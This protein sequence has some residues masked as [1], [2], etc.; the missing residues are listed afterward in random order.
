MATIIVQRVFGRAKDQEKI[1]VFTSWFTDNIEKLETA[2]DEKRP[3][4][5]QFL[6]DYQPQTSSYVVEVQTTMTDFAEE[7]LAK[8]KEIGFDD[9]AM[10][11]DVKN[12]TIREMD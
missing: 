7:C 11:G 1:E 2:V 4:N 10:M 3:S 9:S 12:V 5:G 6:L 8:I